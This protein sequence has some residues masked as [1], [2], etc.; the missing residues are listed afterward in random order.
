MDRQSICIWGII[1]LLMLSGASL[2][3]QQ[4]AMTVEWI[5]SDARAEVEAI[6]RFQWMDNNQAM[7]LNMR[8]SESER[9]FQ[10]FNPRRRTLRS[11]LVMKKALESLE[12]QRGKAYDKKSL[13]WPNSFD[14]KGEQA[15]YIL[16]EDLY[17]LALASAS[18]QRLTNTSA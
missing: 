4:E 15:L 2:F 8:D 17:V 11:A 3:A 6:P 7:W 5:Y 9:T 13:G 10:W 1:Y 18:F 14:K 12:E 16:E